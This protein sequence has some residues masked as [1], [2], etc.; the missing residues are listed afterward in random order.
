MATSPLTSY[1][2]QNRPAPIDLNALHTPHKL[3]EFIVN[4]PDKKNE[5]NFLFKDDPQQLTNTNASSLITNNLNNNTLNVPQIKKRKTRK[6][7]LKKKLKNKKLSK[8]LKYTKD[9]L[10]HPINPYKPNDPTIGMYTHTT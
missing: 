4:V 8:K 7:K 1:S 2:S 6:K 3:A 5:Y 10:N 9:E